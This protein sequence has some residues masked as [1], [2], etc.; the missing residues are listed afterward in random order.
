MSACKKLKIENSSNIGKEE[1]CICGKMENMSHIYYCY[2]TKENLPY[3]K[4]YNGKLKEQET[5]MRRFR[6]NM[7][8]RKKL[9]HE[10]AG[11]SA[12]FCKDISNGINR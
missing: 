12:N 4:L 2:G 10:I 8:I 7:E 5:I 11:R 6:N 3:E 9:I 1:N